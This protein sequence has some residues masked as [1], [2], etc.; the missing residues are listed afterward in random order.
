MSLMRQW[1]LVFAE[2]HSYAIRCSN[3]FFFSP[4]PSFVGRKHTFIFLNKQSAKPF[5]QHR[6]AWMNIMAFVGLT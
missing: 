3:Q 6:A 4:N 5:Q 2:L 1:L